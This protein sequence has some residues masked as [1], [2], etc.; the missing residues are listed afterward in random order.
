[1]EAGRRHQGDEA[2]GRV[3][4]DPAEMPAP[5]DGGELGDG[6]RRRREGAWMAEP[7]GP[8]CDVVAGVLMADAPPV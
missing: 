2:A 4:G 1:M 5:V 3:E 8:R 7:S 6:L